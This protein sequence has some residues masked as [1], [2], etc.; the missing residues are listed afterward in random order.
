VGNLLQRARGRPHAAALLRDD[1]RRTLSDRLG[2]P[3]DTPPS[4]VAD[5]AAARTGVSA[6]RV[7]AAL[8]GPAPASEDDLV[9]LAQ[10]VEAI[11]QEVIRA[12]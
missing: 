12:R 9:G 4:R 8:E 3:P 5:A 2:L 1:L 7:R 11:R 10:T 6:D